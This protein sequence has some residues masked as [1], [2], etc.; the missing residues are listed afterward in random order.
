MREKRKN[1]KSGWLY[2]QL[3]LAIFVALFFSLS[4]T[5]VEL[6]PVM[7]HQKNVEILRS[8]QLQTYSSDDF[9]DMSGEYHLVSQGRVRQTDGIVF[10]ASLLIVI[11]IGGVV[12]NIRNL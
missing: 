1:I 3:I 10:G 2:R 11:I 12:A 4:M 8:D 6:D 5:W 7:D 9:N